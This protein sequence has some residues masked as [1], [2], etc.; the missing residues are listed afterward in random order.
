MHILLW[1]EIT[2]ARGDA[3]TKVTFK[4]CTPFKTCRTETNDVFLDE[5]D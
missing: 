2:I 1:Q 3:N 5:A 4:I